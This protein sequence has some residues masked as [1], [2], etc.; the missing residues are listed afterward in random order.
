MTEDK[1][2]G[3]VIS[4]ASRRNC[5]GVRVRSFHACVAGDPHC[6][7]RDLFDTH[8]RSSLTTPNLS[9]SF[10][11][12]SD[13]EKAPSL[14]NLTITCVM[15]ATVSIATS[16]C[17][18]NP[19]LPNVLEAVREG[20]VQMTS[21]LEAGQNHT[22]AVIAAHSLS[23]LV[24]DSASLSTIVC[25]HE[26]LLNR[27]LR[28]CHPQEANSIDLHI[29]VLLLCV[30]DKTFH[31]DGSMALTNAVTG[32]QSAVLPI[33]AW[34]DASVTM[35]DNCTTRNMT[36]DK[37]LHFRA[38]LFSRMHM[39][40]Q[41]RADIR[42]AFQEMQELEIVDA[43]LEHD[44]DSWNAVRGENEFSCAVC[45]KTSARCF[46]SRCRGINCCSEDCQIQDWNSGHRELCAMVEAIMD[47]IRPPSEPNP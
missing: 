35:P 17:L 9:S 5:T 42:R 39:M 21:A 33:T 2:F 29:V 7:K 31:V 1:W 22:A 45:G 8:L 46:C 44:L 38:I 16:E 37:L 4:A 43:E 32:I 25:E 3:F 23:H 10:S 26:T 36:I 34:E 19:V 15:E 30:V 27:L 40:V 28:A 11:K 18:V 13:Q 41:A 20:M 6:G 14:D 47:R 12:A 24:R